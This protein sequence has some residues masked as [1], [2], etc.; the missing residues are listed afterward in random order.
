MEV[1][2]ASSHVTRLVSNTSGWL[3]FLLTF[4]FDSASIRLPFDFRRNLERASGEPAPAQR[5]PC[6][7][8][9]FPARALA[10]QVGAKLWP[11]SRTLG[12]R[13]MSGRFVY[14]L[15]FEASRLAFSLSHSFRCHNESWLPTSGAGWQTWNRDSNCSNQ[16]DSKILMDAQTNDFIYGKYFLSRLFVLVLFI[17]ISVRFSSLLFASVRFSPLRLASVGWLCFGTQRIR[18]DSNEPT[19]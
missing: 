15:A 10:S 16:S 5:R 7:S 12:E 19:N 17:S 4:G 13:S 9:S 14:E 3:L 1:V 8:R 6:V 2:A 11:S 18:C